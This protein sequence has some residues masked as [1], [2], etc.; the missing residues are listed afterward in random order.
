MMLQYF[1]EKPLKNSLLH[2]YEKSLRRCFSIDACND[3]VDTYIRVYALSGVSY[4]IVH[5][6]HTTCF[7]M[8]DRPESSHFLDFSSEDWNASTDIL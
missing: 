5:N 2:S 1:V 7:V 6:S 4:L 3:A 8:Q